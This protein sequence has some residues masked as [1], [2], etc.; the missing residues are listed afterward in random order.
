MPKDDPC[1]AVLVVEVVEP[2]VGKDGGKQ[3]E[4]AD[5][6]KPRVNLLRY[7]VTLGCVRSDLVENSCKPR[8]ERRRNK[9]PLAILPP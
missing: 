6:A 9:A 3:P 2:P 1:R 7:L 4:D 8:Q 5:R